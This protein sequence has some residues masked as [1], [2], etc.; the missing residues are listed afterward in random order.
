[1][2]MENLYLTI[3]INNKKVTLFINV[4]NLDRVFLWISTQDNSQNIERRKLKV[5]LSPVIKEVN[6]N[7][8]LMI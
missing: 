3:K 7:K 2:I 8:N 4:Q 1:M 6:K 5:N